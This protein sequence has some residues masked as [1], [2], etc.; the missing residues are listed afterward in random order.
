MYLYDSYIFIRKCLYWKQLK[1]IVINTHFIYFCNI[2]A[3]CLWINISNFHCFRSQFNW[4][5]GVMDVRGIVHFPL[6]EAKVK[7]YWCT[8]FTYFS[9]VVSNVIH[10]VLLQVFKVK[11]GQDCF[12]SFCLDGAQ[13]LMLNMILYLRKSE[14]HFFIVCFD[15][16]CYRKDKGQFCDV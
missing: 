10:T 13:C 3:L 12:F 6:A 5:C 1:G 14:G 11:A 8:L 4:S 9:F 16:F 15:F 2:C 7:N